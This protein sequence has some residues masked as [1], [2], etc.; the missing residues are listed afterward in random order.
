MYESMGISSEV[1]DFGEK[2]CDLLK[3]RF[4]RID[5]NAEFNQL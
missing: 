5:E 3:E 1:Y 2:I 4:T